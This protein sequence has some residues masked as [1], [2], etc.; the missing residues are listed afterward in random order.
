MKRVWKWVIGIVVILLVL[1]AFVAVP[2]VMHNRFGP[3]T[4][5][6]I[7][8]RGG[9]GGY[10]P[11][12]MMG[13]NDNDGFGN[14]GYGPGAFPHG[15]MMGRGFG[16]QHPMMYGFGF[17]PFGIFILIIPLVVLGL[18]IYGFVALLMRRP[19]STVPVEVAPAAPTQ[20]CGN[21]GKSIQAD[22]KTCPYCG[23][24]L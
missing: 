11:G 5:Y 16:F 3:Q 24:S 21:C 13:R 8:E 10:G 18:A 15:G 20:S 6:G 9:E 17:F 14:R 2:F 22:W 1:A 12:W 4:A 7:Q 23:H 19:A